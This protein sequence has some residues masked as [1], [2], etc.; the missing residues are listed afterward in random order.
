MRAIGEIE[1]QNKENEEESK[2]IMSRIKPDKEVNKVYLPP[3]EVFEANKFPTQLNTSIPKKEVK[4]K[5]DMGLVCVQTPNIEENRDAIMKDLLLNN[6]PIIPNEEQPT[7]HIKSSIQN[8]TENIWQVVMKHENHVND[9]DQKLN[10]LEAEINLI[11]KD[12]AIRITQ[13]EDYNYLSQLD[14]KCLRLE[15][16]MHS[17]LP[18]IAFGNLHINPRAKPYV[19]VVS[20]I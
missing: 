13:S 3:F 12:I 2:T 17:L 9:I 16:M 5:A 1:Q 18:S 11:A 14:N 15:K 20:T 10:I 4:V 7:P 19:E 6:L 8:N